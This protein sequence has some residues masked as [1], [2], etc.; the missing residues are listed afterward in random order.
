MKERLKPYSFPMSD[1]L[2]EAL[3]ALADA[4]HRLLANYIRATLE[5]HVE[6][7]RKKSPTIFESKPTAEAVRSP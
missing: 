2:R 5:K 7:Q 6:A 4:D 1:E 3:Q